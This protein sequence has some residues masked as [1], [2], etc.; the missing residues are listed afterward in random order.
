MRG[1]R[2]CRGTSTQAERPEWAPLLK[3]VG[4]EITGDFMW[5]F[6]VVLTD[7][8]SLQA[9]KHIDTRGYIHLASTGE[10]F[11][12]ESPDR[13]RTF[14]AADVLAA[15]FAAL[16]GLAGVTDEQIRASWAAVERLRSRG[17]R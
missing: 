4:E 7:G 13:Y 16:P 12:Y 8:M 9:Y 1:D 5:M 10:A 11:V 17:R 15:V 2:V 14:P 6:E 3:A